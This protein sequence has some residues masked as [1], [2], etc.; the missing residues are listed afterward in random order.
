MAESDTRAGPSGRPSTRLLVALCILLGGCAADSRLLNRPNAVAIAPDGSLLVV[1]KNHYRVARLDPSGRLIGEFGGLGHSPGSLP[2]PYDIA[3]GPNGEIY[4]CDREYAPGGAFKDHDGVKVFT[5][6]GEPLREIGAHDYKE[7]ES[8]NG[9]YGLDVDSQGN[10]YVADFHRGRIRLFD[11]RGELVRT[12]GRPGSGPGELGGPNDV[13]VDEARRIVYVLESIN[14]RVQSF[15]LDGEPLARFGR[16]GSEREAL[17]YPQYL[18]LD[19]EGNLYISDMGNRCVKKFSPQG[20][21]LQAYAPPAEPGADS[22]LMGVTVRQ[23]A[24]PGGAIE[25][26][27]VDTL[28]NRI[29]VFDTLAGLRATLG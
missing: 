27:A 19:A 13:A 18:D 11:R 10:V 21:F 14:S 15:T 3:L 25:V 7:G 20:E 2:A 22:Q 16:F 29:L 8:N 4:L 17:S 24:G 28:N 23:A 9:P 26:L 12:I 6:D 1:D 5:A